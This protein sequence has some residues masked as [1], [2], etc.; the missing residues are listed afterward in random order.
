MEVPQDLQ[1]APGPR[2]GFDPYTRRGIATKD[3]HVESRFSVRI[4]RF[5]LRSEVDS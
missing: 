4:R 2:R 1:V 3:W 5:E